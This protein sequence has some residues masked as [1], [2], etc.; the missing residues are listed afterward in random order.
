M[1]SFYVVQ[2]DEQTLDIQKFLS[3]EDFLRLADSGGFIVWNHMGKK[4]IIPVFRVQ[5]MAAFIRL[6]PGARWS[7]TDYNTIHLTSEIADAILGD[8]A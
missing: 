3:K 1:R 7:F 2:C 4:F 8:Q 5:N 6:S